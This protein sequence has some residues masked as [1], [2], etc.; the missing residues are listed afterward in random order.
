[1]F[2]I[3]IQKECRVTCRKMFHVKQEYC[4]IFLKRRRTKGDKKTTCVVMTQVVLNVSFCYATISNGFASR[5]AM[6]DPNRLVSCAYLRSDELR[7]TS[8]NLAAVSGAN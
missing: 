8:T 7:I 6:K 1:M 2:K 3:T 4:W 5:L